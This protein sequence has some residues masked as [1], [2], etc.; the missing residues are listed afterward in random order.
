VP[1]GHKKPP[2]AMLCAG[3]LCRSGSVPPG[4][5]LVDRRVY[6]NPP[7]A[8][9]DS[10]NVA[11]TNPSSVG[12]LSCRSRVQRDAWRASRLALRS[13]R[14][15][16]RGRR[17]GD[18]CGSFDSLHHI[19]REID[20]RRSNGHVADELD[21]QALAAIL[22]YREALGCLI[23]RQG[24]RELDHLSRPRHRLV[25]HPHSIVKRF[26]FIK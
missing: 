8:R 15:C 18:S 13:S 1:V 14:P 2:D 22:Q 25:L 3:G 5:V 6:H 26:G 7:A 19:R 4:C 11:H 21:Q 10:L 24:H 23:G 17:R 16:D 12:R 20:E 9:E